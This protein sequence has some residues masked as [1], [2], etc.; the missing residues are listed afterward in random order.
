MI[1]QIRS[2]G[3]RICHCGDIGAMPPAA[4]IGRIKRCDVLMIPVGEVC[5]MDISEVTALIDLVD[6]KVVIPMHYHVSGLTMPL[7]TLER[8]TD[9]VNGGISKVGKEMDISK[10]EFPASRE[11]WKFSR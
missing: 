6:P 11:Y 5:T 9:A 7:R 3:M 10:D 1:Y 2:D 8:F 4:T